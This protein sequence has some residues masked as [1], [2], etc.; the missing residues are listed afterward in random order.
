MFEKW[1]ITTHQDCL[2]IIATI[3][4]NGVAMCPNSICRL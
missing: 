2:L 4:C 1:E 3:V